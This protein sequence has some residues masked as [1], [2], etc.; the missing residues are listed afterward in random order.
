MSLDV[1]LMGKSKK[2]EFK[3]VICDNIHYHKESEEL[4]HDNI[5]HNLNVMADKA[6]IY[7]ALWRPEE[8]NCIKAKDIIDIL[9]TGLL[10]LKT[11]ISHFKTFNPPNDWGNYDI[12]VSFV[13]KYLK[14]CIKYPNAIIKVSR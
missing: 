5:T 10:D 11:N 9:T 3:C 6:G 8:I 4:Y 13:T 1:Y 2:V 7:K 12:L 14:T